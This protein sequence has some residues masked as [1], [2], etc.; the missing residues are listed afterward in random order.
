MEQSLLLQLI[1]EIHRALK[2]I[3][4]TILWYFLL[5]LLLTKKIFSTANISIYL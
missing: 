4:K 3:T 5:Y 1:L 2:C